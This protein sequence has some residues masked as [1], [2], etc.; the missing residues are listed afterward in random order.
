MFLGGFFAVA[1]IGPLSLGYISVAP[2]TSDPLPSAVTD[3]PAVTGT[4]TPA[5]PTSRERTQ[6]ETTD[7]QPTDMETTEGE[8]TEASVLRLDGDERHTLVNERIHSSVRVVGPLQKGFDAKKDVVINGRLDLSAVRANVKFGDNSRV[9]RMVAVERIE[10]GAKVAVSDD[11]R[12]GAI[13]VKTVTD[14]TL[15]LK[16]GAEVESGVAVDAVEPE[17]EVKIHGAVGM[18]EGVHIGSVNGSVEVTGDVLINGDLVIDSV[19]S[20][21]ELSVDGDHTI[22]GDL[23]VRDVADDARIDIDEDA[24]DGDIVIEGERQSSDTGG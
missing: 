8:T 20:E 3:T 2:S 18:G 7:P 16:D 23:I 14:G 12:V 1:G 19:G 9:T 6:S 21:G 11:A 15:E 4:T 5:A 17:G 13:S 22:R 24:V 10:E